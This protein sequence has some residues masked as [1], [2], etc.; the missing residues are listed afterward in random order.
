MKKIIYFLLILTINNVYSQTYELDKNTNLMT[1]SK[2]VE[3]SSN[4]DELFAQFKISLAQIFKNYNEVKQL[5]DKETKTFIIK[6]Y[7]DTKIQR[8]WFKEDFGGCF[9]NLTIQCKDNKYR[10]II[11]NIN[12]SCIYGP[13]DCGA[14]GPIENEKIKGYPKKQWMLVQDLAKEYSLNL[15]DQIESKVKENL[16]KANEKW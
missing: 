10:I 16:A 1:Y 4:S 7:F 8:G 12:H 5:E 6:G 3:I 11:D 13:S 15:G 9:Y 14:G 2:V